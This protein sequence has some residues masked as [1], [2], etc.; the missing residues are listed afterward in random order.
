[1][2]AAPGR[3]FDADRTSISAYGSAGRGLAT[4]VAGRHE[5]SNYGHQIVSGTID[6]TKESSMQNQRSRQIFTFALVLGAMVFGMVLAGSSELV[7]AGLAEADPTPSQAVHVAAASP[8]QGLPSL[9]DLAEAVS[10]AVVSIQVTQF[11]EER[12]RSGNPFEFFFDQRRRRQPQQPQQPPQEEEEPQQRRSRSSGSGFVISSDGYIITN[13]HVIENADGLTVN[14]GGR[15]YEAEVKGDDPATDLALIKIEPEGPIPYLDLGDS[16]TLRVGDWV[17]VI[18]SPLQLE[19]SVSVG[20]VS[21]KGRAINITADSSLEK[22]IQTDAAINFGNS[23]GPLVDLAGRVVGIATAINFGAENI[24][25]AVPV[26]TLREILPQLRDHGSVERGYLGVD[27]RDLNRETAEAF[28]LDSTDGSLVEAVR[29]DGPAEDGGVNHGDVILEVDGT[30]VRTNRELI[31][32]ISARRP[33]ATVQ[34]TLWR[35]GKSIK[36]KIK[37]GQRPGAQV[38]EVEVESEERGSIDWLGIE[39]SDLNTSLRQNHGIDSDIDGVW[40]TDVDATSPLVE[41]AAQVVPGD[42]ITEVNGEK[43][44]SVKRFEEVVEAAESGSFLRMYITSFNPQRNGASFFAIV[45]VP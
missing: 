22:F 36:K 17:M 6:T 27:I 19:N 37:L 16:D 25:F 44:D 29:E 21:A 23:G 32:N 30:R 15:R 4:L 9:A 11:V 38:A 33:G 26:G 13:H 43:V 3:R 40:V 7:P 24:G 20:V 14:L 1:M 10:P 45:R 2:A 35:N 8:V 34:L 39:Y 28:G 5:A 31:D 41:Q 12:P 42:V 18:G